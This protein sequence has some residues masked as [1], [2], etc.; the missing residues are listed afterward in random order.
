[1]SIYTRRQKAKSH[2]RRRCINQSINQS[3]KSRSRQI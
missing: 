1:M 2:Y 3:I